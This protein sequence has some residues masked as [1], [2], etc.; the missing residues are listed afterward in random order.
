MHWVCWTLTIV[1]RYSFV[2][3]TVAGVGRL[4][5]AST[6]T[7]NRRTH[8][9]GGQGV[10]DIGATMVTFVVCACHVQ[11]LKTGDE[12]KVGVKTGDLVLF[13]KQGF[14]EVET[15]TGPI[16]FVYDNSILATLER[17]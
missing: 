12:V 4:P 11:V 1:Y 17:S 9:S 10:F 13:V 8:R 7:Y 3:K 15:E 6:F 14:S 5:N 16:Y 2:H